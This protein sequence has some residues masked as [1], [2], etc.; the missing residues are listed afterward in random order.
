MRATVDTNVAIVANG[1]ETNATIDCRVKATAFLSEMLETGAIVIDEAGDVLAEYMTYLNPSGQPGVG[2]QFI[3]LI[4][5]FASNRVERVNIE[6][7][8]G[9]YIDFPSDPRLKSF[10]RSDRKFVALSIRANCTVANATD[11]DWLEHYDALVE[12]GVKIEFVCGL[13]TEA[14]HERQ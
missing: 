1:R 7:R 8:A 13:D 10:D 14:W 6:K 2:D 5:S 12:N 3:R 9:A 4:L 11:S